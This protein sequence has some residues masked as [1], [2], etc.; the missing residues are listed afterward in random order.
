MIDHRGENTLIISTNPSTFIRFRKVKR[1]LSFLSGMRLLDISS[2]SL[3][4]ITVR[5]HRVRQPR[6]LKFL[7]NYVCV[8]QHKKKQDTNQFMQDM[9]DE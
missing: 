6:G 3:I 8:S 2:H 4:I 5:L 9:F 1:K 7:T